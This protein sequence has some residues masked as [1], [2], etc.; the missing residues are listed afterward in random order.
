VLNNYLSI[1]EAILLWLIIR[2]FRS[3][4]H[5]SI[6]GGSGAHRNAGGEA[7][8]CSGCMYRTSNHKIISKKICRQ[9]RDEL[10]F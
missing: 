9:L 5:D 10:R 7:E 2:A 3:E 8:E 4:T 1:A 6:P